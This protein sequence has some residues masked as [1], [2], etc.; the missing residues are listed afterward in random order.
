MPKR[1]TLQQFGERVRDLRRAAG[2]SQ[3]KLAEEASLHRTYLSGVERGA[4]NPSLSSIARIAKA[5]KVSL[6]EMM[7]G[8]E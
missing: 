1:T 7:K 3:E 2:L 6:T 4:R 5:L 8:V